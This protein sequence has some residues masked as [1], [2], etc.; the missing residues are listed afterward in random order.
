MSDTTTAT[1]QP[2][3]EPAAHDVTGFAR[4]P[5]RADARR[6]YERLLTAAGDAFAENGTAASLEDI[7]RRAEVGIGTL[8]RHFPTRQALVEAVYV[9]EVEAVAAKARDLDG[10]E[11]WD[12]LCTWLRAFVRYAAAKKALTEELL[13]TMDA[14]APVLVSC[15]TAIGDAGDRLLKRAQDAGEV[16][17]DVKFWDVGRMVAGIAAI[18]TDDPTQIDRITEVALDGLRYRRD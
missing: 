14:D 4:R 12:A 7:A 11:P 15:K 1:E 17:T 16:R 5:K 3:F 9:D 18:K 13:N 10:L 2:P 8:Y 6:N